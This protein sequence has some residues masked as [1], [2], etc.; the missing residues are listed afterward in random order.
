MQMTR[1]L[2]SRLGEIPDGRQG[3]IATLRIMRSFVKEGKTL[4]PVRMKAVA[5][6]NGLA[7]KD[8]AGEVRSLSNFVRDSIRYVRDVSDVETIQSAD[9]TLTQGAGDCDDKSVLLA[10]LLESLSH[11]TRFVAVGTDNNN[12]IHVYVET[13]IGQSWIKLET[14]EPVE[15]GQG[16]VGFPAKLYIHN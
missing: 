5:L 6:T 11:P 7:Q 1:P 15:C 9:F 13:L 14:T 2:S 12:F 4:L 8:Y 3:T 10:S 16:P